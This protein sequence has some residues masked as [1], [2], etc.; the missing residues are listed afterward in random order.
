MSNITETLVQDPESC[1][2]LKDL[3]FDRECIG[4][5]INCELPE[6]KSF[7][8]DKN[9]D[10]NWGNWFKNST[11]NEYGDP[12]NSINEFAIPTY[13]QV[14]NWAEEE[15]D[16]SVLIEKDYEVIYW[17]VEVK[18]GNEE[19]VIYSFRHLSRRESNEAMIKAIIDYIKKNKS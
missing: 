2:A 4:Y 18:I 11:L 16:I 1:K 15:Y 7:Y 14:K 3:G 6:P 10:D 13:E 5:Y 12:T 9:S 19:K 8:H 17:Y